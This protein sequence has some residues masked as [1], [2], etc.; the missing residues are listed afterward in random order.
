MKVKPPFSQLE[1][2]ILNAMYERA[3]GAYN[4]YTL[5]SVLHPADKPGDVPPTAFNDTRDAVESLIQ[6]GLMNGKRL[7]G[8]DGV[9]FTELKLSNKGQQEAIRHRRETMGAQ[10]KINKFM[11]ELRKESE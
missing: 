6:H 1:G 8:N 2:G 9:Y 11:A 7:N 4:T 3:D 10:D 5:H